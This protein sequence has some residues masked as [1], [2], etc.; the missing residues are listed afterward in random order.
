MYLKF[1]KRFA[2]RFFPKNITPEKLALSQMT[3]THPHKFP[4]GLYNYPPSKCRVT[5]CS[6]E[7]K[8]K[9]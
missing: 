9:D 7:K 1:C 4:K 2:E 6:R 5:G 3:L 8:I